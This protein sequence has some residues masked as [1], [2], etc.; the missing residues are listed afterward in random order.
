MVLPC[1]IAYRHAGPRRAIT[2]S[3]FHWPSH[4]A[5]NRGSIFSTASSLPLHSCH[6]GHFHPPQACVSARWIY[7]RERGKK[8]SSPR[9]VSSFRRAEVVAARLSIPWEKTFRWARDGRKWEISWRQNGRRLKTHGLAGNDETGKRVFR[10]DG[11]L[12]VL[13]PW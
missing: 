10:D 6:L 9:I 3:Y 13:V 4:Q 5:G 7:E 2:A 8:S 1:V 12:H 11:R